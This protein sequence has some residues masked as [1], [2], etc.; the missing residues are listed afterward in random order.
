MLHRNMDRSWTWVLL[1]PLSA[2]GRCLQEEK[3]LSIRYPRGRSLRALLHHAHRSSSTV[4]LGARGVSRYGSDC[5]Y[6]CLHEHK[7]SLTSATSV[8]PLSSTITGF[9]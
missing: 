6:N 3:V 8:G 4:P 9:P 7:K 2:A 1:H 5:G